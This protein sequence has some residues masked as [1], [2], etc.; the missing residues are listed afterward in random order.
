M[1]KLA[2]T[3]NPYSPVWLETEMRFTRVK[4]ERTAQPELGGSELHQVLIFW[5]AFLCIGID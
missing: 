1:W 3:S 5:E 2:H 4:S